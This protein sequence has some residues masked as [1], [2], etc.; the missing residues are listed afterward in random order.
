MSKKQERILTGI[1]LFFVC[2]QLAHFVHNG[3]YTYGHTAQVQRPQMGGTFRLALPA[4]IQTTTRIFHVNDTSI[5]A[6]AFDLITGFSALYLLYLM[7]VD[8]PLEE[9]DRPKDRALKILFF[10]AIIQFPL[11]WVVPWQRPETMPSALFLAFSLFCL[12]KIEKN[13][14]WSLPLLAAVLIQ[15]LV[16]TDVPLVFGAATAFVGLWSLVKKGS[17]GKFRASMDYIVIGSLIALISAGIQV[18]LH[19]LYPQA[20]VDIQFGPNSTFHN[21]EILTIILAPFVSF[22][23]LL[24]VYRPPL[25]AVEKVAMAS[26]LLYLPMYFTFGLVTEARIYVPF[27]L[28]M[29]MVTARVSASFLSARFDAAT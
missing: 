27:L 20:S 11:A 21:L 7:T 1:F 3:W 8:L 16:R 26:A 14:L 22:A 19:T 15:T 28:I 4:L 2:V 23:L 5:T 13:R 10:L 12:A 25:T 6:A 24:M 29:C 18:Y 17:Q 9:P